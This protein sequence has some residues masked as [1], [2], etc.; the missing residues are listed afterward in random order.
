MKLCLD[1]HGL[2]TQAQAAA[3]GVDGNELRR[4]LRARTVRLVRRGVYVHTELF[5][6]VD[7]AASHRVDVG[8]ALLSR[9][10]HLGS[11]L[12]KPP[13]PRLAAGGLSAALLWGLAAPLPELYQ[14]C[15]TATRMANGERRVT[16]LRHHARVVDLVSADRCRRTIRWGVRVSPSS[17]P[18]EH[19]TLSGSIPLTTIARTTIDL[20][21]EL[22]LHQ[23]V[24]VADSALRLGTKRAELAVAAAYCRAWRGGRQALEVVEFADDRAES[25]AESLARAVFLQQGL[26][27]PQSQVNVWDRDGLVGRVDFLFPGRRTAVEVDGK[28]KYLDPHCAAGEVLW[29]EKLREDRL[30]ETGLEVVR[31]TWDQLTGVPDLVAERIRRAFARASRIAG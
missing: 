24:M 10:I 26:P 11:Q 23:A 2:F 25:P 22:P 4:L 7:A 15:E 30:R 8:G 3:H 29:Q 16:R 13:P 12:V 28:I 19:L 31:V 21:R 20:A 17:L 5:P 27:R 6:A 14:P 18:A 1:Q 9:Q